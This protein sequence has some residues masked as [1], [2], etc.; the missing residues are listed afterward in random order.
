MDLQRQRNS[1]G[2]AFVYHKHTSPRVFFPR[3]INEALETVERE[4]NAVFWAGGTE[5]SCL[6]MSKN[7]IELPRT[8]ISLGLVEELTRASRS[9][10]GLDIGAMMTLERLSA[11]GEKTLPTG[12]YE[13]IKCI[14]SL[15][16]RNRATIG[17]N[18]ALQTRI[19]DLHPILQLLDT[20]IEIRGS[21]RG[22]RKR[23]SVRKIP[24]A[25]LD[26]T[27]LLNS[28]ELISKIS[29]PTDN[30]DI[31]F[32]RKI[33]PSGNAKKILIFT[34]LASAEEGVLSE[35][36]MSFSNGYTEILRDRELEANMA[37][38][39]LPF[40]HRELKI[41]DEGILELT[42]PW[43][44]RSYDRETAIACARGFLKLIEDNS[45]DEMLL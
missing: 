41:L 21:R 39:P 27:D 22:G 19:G 17:G 16:L 44:A 13:V 35:C 4:S 10:Y 8:V 24:I 28:R 33:L 29:I 3:T 18:I 12:L 9:E 25:L 15:P 23:N 6:S 1:D 5:L 45:M 36:R 2:S 30:W 26:K 31:G 7:L 42:A 14:G 34:A 37:G 40:G 11:I 43:K 20:R 38:Q 32:Y